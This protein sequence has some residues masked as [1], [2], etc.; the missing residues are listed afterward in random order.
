M[1]VF[2]VNKDKNYIVMSKEHLKEKKMSLKAKGLLSQMLS[3]PDEWD[4]SIAGLVS[5]NKE[6]E[7]SIKTTLNELKQFGYLKITKLMPNQ[8]ETGRIEYIY[9]I[10]EK[11]QD[12]E[13]QGV[14]NLGVEILGVEIQP[15][16]N[17]W[18]LNNKEL[19]NKKINNKE[20]NNKVN[21]IIEYLNNKINSNYKSTTKTT[22]EKI[23]ARLNEGFT[24]EDFKIVIDKKYS[25][26]T[27]TEF[28]KFLRP[29]TLFGTK[30]ENYLNQPII[31]KKLKDISLQ[32]LEAMQN[33]ANR[34]YNS[35]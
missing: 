26:W 2:R 23:K 11:K 28:E 1:S 12:S 34:I 10:Y 33:E 3:L 7:T 21:Y 29:E 14:E 32:E 8:T 35:N 13:K 25:E 15:V 4:Y 17:Q 20:L 19:N 31:K 6:N 16:E 9:D 18:L 27:G 24:L 22:R 30:F 5:L